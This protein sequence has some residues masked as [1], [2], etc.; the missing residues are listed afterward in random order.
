[1]IKLFAY[2]LFL[3]MCFT[4]KLIDFRE[5]VGQQVDDWLNKM[6]HTLVPSN[7]T[8]RDLFVDCFKSRKEKEIS[9]EHDINLAI[10]YL[11]Q[12]PKQERNLTYGGTDKPKG[13]LIDLA[14]ATIL[15]FDSVHRIDPEVDFA[16]IIKTKLDSDSHDN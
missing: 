2:P 11:K 13:K 6:N 5:A 15:I 8:F 14:T 7:I 10:L 4:G 3:I 16:R 9:F 12:A 1:M